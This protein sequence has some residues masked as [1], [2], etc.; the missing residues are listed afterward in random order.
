MNTNI[1]EQPTITY[2]ALQPEESIKNGVTLTGFKIP[3]W[4]LVFFMVKLGIASLPAAIILFVISSL[5]SAT[6][7]GFILG[8]SG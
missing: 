3:F 5:F 6:I 4:D 8:I 7:M 1:T 2:A